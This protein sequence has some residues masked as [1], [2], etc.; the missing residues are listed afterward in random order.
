MDAAQ[1]ERLQALP[2]EQAGRVDAEHRLALQDAATVVPGPSRVGRLSRLDAMQPQAMAHRSAQRLA[3]Q[4]R[5][6]VAALGRLHGGRYG[7]CRAC[8]GK[9]DRQRLLSDPATPSWP[10][11]QVERDAAR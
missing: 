7:L 11:G 9:V 8:G 10:D 1:T 5:R 4:K 3:V 6:I 2:R